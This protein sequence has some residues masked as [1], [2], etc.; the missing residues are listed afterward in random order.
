MIHHFRVSDVAI[1]S[2]GTLFEIVILDG[3][4]C[5]LTEAGLEDF[6]RQHPISTGRERNTDGQSEE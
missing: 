4:D 5:Q 3:G 2:N 6:I 1:W